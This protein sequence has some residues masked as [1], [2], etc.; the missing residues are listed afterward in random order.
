MEN[1]TNNIVENTEVIET[2]E[3]IATNSGLSKG[4]KIAAGTGLAVLVSGL[5]YKF[6]FKPVFAK[7]KTNKN[8][9]TIN[10]PVE[11]VESDIEF[12]ANVNEVEE[13]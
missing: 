4:F 13:D 7:I 12:D 9:K 1:V 8:Q 11:I 3:K 5:A 2:A 10:Q 6:V